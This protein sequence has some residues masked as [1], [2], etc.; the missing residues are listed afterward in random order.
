MSAEAPALH[1]GLLTG[2]GARKLVVRKGDFWGTKKM[3]E[4][5]VIG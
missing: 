4:K 1:L 5:D 2:T 3:E